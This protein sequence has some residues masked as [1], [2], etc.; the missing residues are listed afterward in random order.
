MWEWE[1][2]SYMIG[3]EGYDDRQ[4]IGNIKMRKIP[5]FFSSPPASFSGPGYCIL[6]A[7]VSEFCCSMP[8][9]FAIRL[10]SFTI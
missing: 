10:C 7:L 2:I 8:R 6:V 3:R 1:A 4:W 9:L 5:A